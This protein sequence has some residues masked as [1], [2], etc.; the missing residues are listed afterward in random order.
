MNSPLWDGVS[1]PSNTQMR[2]ESPSFEGCNAFG[3]PLSSLVSE[4]L[5][6]P[7]NKSWDLLTDDDCQLIRESFSVMKSPVYLS[8]LDCL[9]NKYLG[10]IGSSLDEDSWDGEKY[11]KGIFTD[12]K[13]Y[14]NHEVWERVVA[15]TQAYYKEQF[16]FQQGLLTWCL[17]GASNGK[18]YFIDKVTGKKYYDSDRQLLVNDLARFPSSYLK[19]ENGRAKER[20]FIDVLRE[21]GYLGT[22]GSVWP[23][24]I[25]GTRVVA[26]RENL[27]FNERLSRQDALL[28]PTD[29]RVV[30]YLSPSKN[31][32]KFFFDTT[33]SRGSKMFDDKTIEGR[34]FRTYIEYIRTC[35]ARGGIAGGVF[36][37]VDD[38]SS[39]VFFEELFK[40]CKESNIQLITKAAA[41]D[42]CF[43]HSF[44]DGNLIRN[45]GFVNTVESYFKDSID[46]PKNPDGYVGKCYV[47]EGNDGRILVT[48][49][50]VEYV[51][52]GVPF[53]ELNYSASVCGS[54]SIVFSVITN[55]TITS[56]NH[57]V[58]S[59]ANNGIMINSIS[60]NSVGN[61]SSIDVP[62]YIED[63]PL[64]E[65]E[66]ICEGWGEKIM[67]LQILYSGGLHVKNVSLIKN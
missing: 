25:D 24:K 51:L 5:S 65:Y 64:T 57:G 39:R 34:P 61:F 7:I 4:T 22:H 13:T 11:T 49:D 66:Q 6:V 37:S 52:Y 20:S 8:L 14:A 54:G 50:N 19:D 30:D 21:Y 48:E 46:I 59:Y 27:F 53:G 3:L 63:K 44:F 9:S 18:L 15:I 42:I 23:S 32:T 31:Y 60:I 35:T 36:D 41:Y 29:L 12:C 38:Y 55:D 47:E 40:W 2:E 56:Y 1:F 28:Y 10:T 33:P 43:N 16:G 67:G 58:A 26:M 45:P 62:M 17:P